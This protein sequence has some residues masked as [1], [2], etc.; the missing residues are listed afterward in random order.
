MTVL[1]IASK[2]G[3]YEICK[4]ILNNDDFKNFVCE[5]S[6]EG[7]NACHYAAEAGSVKLLRLLLDNG[8]DAKAVTENK[9]NILHIACIYNQL[10]MCKF[11]FDTFGDLVD[12]ES[13]DGWTAAL[14]AAKNG[15]TDFL[16]F[17]ASKKVSLDHKSES[18]RN[19]LHIAC[20]NGHLKACKFLT[21]TCPSLL[22]APDERGRYP[23][24]FAA[25][26]GNLELLI[27]LEAKTELTKETKT[28]MNILHM[29]CLYDHI[30]MCRYI[31]D[32]Y[33]DLN[34]KR[35]ENGWTTA[36]YV[37][38]KVNKRG[39]KI[40]IFEMLLKADNPVNIMHLS[41]NG[42]S[43]LTLAIKYNVCELAEYLFEKHSNLL[44]IPN[45]NDPWE[46]GNE[47]PKML[48][49]LHNYLDRPC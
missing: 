14:H 16:D 25:R 42:N 13:N 30:E 17:L 44:H 36:H 23:V 35:S 21:K 34:V 46:T 48:E 31:L 40:E 22:S 28:G 24:H 37:A 1:H 4:F 33:P 43:V 18:N 45:A 27:Y 5:K 8:I 47:H 38:G 49:I 26:S 15:N 9:L 32:R 20:G 12:A 10:E 19:S 39:K 6:S 41:K 7:K 29:A 3:S 11:I 2:Y